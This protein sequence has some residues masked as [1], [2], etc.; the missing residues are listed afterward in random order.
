MAS[1]NISARTSSVK[2]IFLSAGEQ[3]GDLH[4]SA[5]IHELKEQCNEYKL[6]FY[7]LGGDRMSSEG[8]KLLYHIR[9]LSTIGFLDVIKKYRF[10]K[11]VLKEC[12]KFVREV[13]PDIIILTDYPG[14]N[15]AFA[16]KLRTFYTKKIIYYISPQIWA[17]HQKRVLTIKKCIDKV[18]V[19]FPFEL[20]FYKKYGIDAV[21]TGHPLVSRIKKFLSENQ[22][23]KKV[24]GEPKVVSILPGSRKD[25][26]LH[27]LPI[28]LETA[29][30]LGKE[31]EI[32]VNISKAE[33]IDES[34]FH[35]FRNTLDQFNL[36]GEN[37]YRM[38][39]NSDLVM[40]KAGTAT[41]ECALIG[42][43]FLIF[44]K[45]FLLNYYLL[46][47]I[48]KVSNLGMVNILAKENFIRE[49]IQHDF[50]V[51]NLL[52]ESR[53]ILTDE[54]Y[55]SIMEEKLKSIWNILGDSDAASS[56]VQQIKPYLDVT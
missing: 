54:Q 42:T 4:T 33:G 14:F 25:E 3:S 46:K 38:I 51:N 1:E 44:Y 15:L 50:T 7:G 56:A 53:K 27:H 5:L 35:K 52:A 8:V 10:F 34:I 32:E 47:P 20:D 45:T 26:I 13:D 2:K 31:F 9:E 11:K 55:R 16:E 43:P 41:M 18:L 19:V 28:L 36:T 39:L 24:Y 29:V 37:V 21:Y 6:E 30:Q 17:W 48:V 49:F 40:S 23:K 12:V 22:R